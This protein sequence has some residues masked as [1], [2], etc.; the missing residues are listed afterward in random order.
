[1]K[2]NVAQTASETW[3]WSE[4]MKEILSAIRAMQRLISNTPVVEDRS[5]LQDKERDNDTS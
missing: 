3:T 5:G 1:M 4:M 2:E